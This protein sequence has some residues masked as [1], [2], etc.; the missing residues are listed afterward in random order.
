M[1]NTDIPF[2]L[3]GIDGVVSVDY[4]ANTDSSQ[5]GYVLE[6]GKVRISDLLIG[7]KEDWDSHVSF[8][9]NKYPNWS[10]V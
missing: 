9:V 3:R 10:F 2:H 5:W 4:R 8:L 1:I 6:H 7:S